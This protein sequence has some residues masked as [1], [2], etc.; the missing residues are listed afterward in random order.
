MKT[1]FRIVLISLLSLLL[2]TIVLNTIGL[3]VNWLTE[4]PFEKYA[5]VTMYA[6]LI[7][8]SHA[9]SRMDYTY[10]GTMLFAFVYLH[11]YCFYICYY[12]LNEIRERFFN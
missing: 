12:G 11:A 8:F 3:G 4:R 5:I 9:T 1:L 2:S 10:Q 6:Y 7:D